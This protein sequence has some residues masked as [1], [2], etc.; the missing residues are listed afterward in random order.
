MKV[1][2]AQ[3]AGIDAMLQGARLHRAESKLAKNA[4]LLEYLTGHKQEQ[5][6]G[7]RNVSMSNVLAKLG[8]IDLAVGKATAEKEEADKQ[9]EI[10]AAYERVGMQGGNPKFDVVFTQH[11]SPGIQLLSSPV[12]GDVWIGDLE[13]DG[14]AS[15]HPAMAA[16]MAMAA[17][18][19]RRLLLL[20]IDGPVLKGQKDVAA[21]TR[22]RRP[23]TLRIQLVDREA[24]NSIRSIG[25]GGSLRRLPSLEQTYAV[26][27]QITERVRQLITSA[28]STLETVAHL[29]EPDGA[30][31]DL[32]QDRRA[33]LARGVR[34]PD[35]QGWILEPAVLKLW[36]SSRDGADIT[37]GLDPES[38]A[39]ALH[40]LALTRQLAPQPLD[41]RSSH[42]SHNLIISPS[43]PQKLDYTPGLY[44]FGSPVRD[45]RSA[46]DIIGRPSR[47]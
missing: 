25:L 5:G 32:R 30:L 31:F 18:S 13:D 3:D 28:Q 45:A 38:A 41:H 21:I 12:S 40:L 16:A 33:V 8:L 37:E 17:M 27:P 7:G 23:M 20:G 29:A 2:R 11:G 44:G 22:V 15:H 46:P 43:G 1:N 10:N 35:E 14:P 39:V 19:R 42:S 9:R 34:G 36:R 4:E 26:M 24:F 6:H 47:F